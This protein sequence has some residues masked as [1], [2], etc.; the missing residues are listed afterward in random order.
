MLG[1]VTKSLPQNICALPDGCNV[2]FSLP[3]RTLLASLPYF[4][5]IFRPSGHGPHLVVGNTEVIRWCVS[6]DVAVGSHLT[7]L[8]LK[9][10]IYRLASVWF[11]F[12]RIIVEFEMTYLATVLSCSN[13]C[14]FHMLM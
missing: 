3:K 10:K 5:K 1:D 7:M 2:A 11:I 9:W 4:C 8:S 13:S 12:H 14:V 6:Y